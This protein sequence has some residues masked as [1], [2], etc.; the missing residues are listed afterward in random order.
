MHRFFLPPQQAQGATVTLSERDAH[1]ALRVLRL[2][3]GDAVTVLDGMGNELSCEV[4]EAG[5]NE[6][7]LSVKQ[8]RFTPPPPCAVTLVQAVA[9]GKAMELI[10]QKAA[11]LGAHRVVPVL[12][13]RS[14]AQIGDE[15]AARKVEKW[16]AIA[17]ESLKQCGSPWLPKIDVPCALKDFLARGAK[18]DL[19]FVASLHEGAWHPRGHFQDFF[20]RQNRAPESVAV[21]VGPEGDFTP[22]EMG[23]LIAAGGRPITLG[24][25]V[26]RC[27]TAAIACL[28]VLNYELQD[29]E[30]FPAATKSV[31]PGRSET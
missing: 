13:E 29:P 26:L 4:L 23:K 1:H 10:V 3:R 11:E 14:V 17:I 7:L 30:N 27:E 8:R 6:V 25:R 15:D 18:F 24:P 22:A 9:K 20:Q 2:R 31:A 28:A 16:E 5:R 21:W 19:Q 12:V